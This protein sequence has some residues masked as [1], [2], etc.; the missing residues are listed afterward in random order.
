MQVMAQA[1]RPWVHV[2]VGIPG[3]DAD[4]HSGMPSV[5]SFVFGVHVVLRS[6]ERGRGRFNAES[7]GHERTVHQDSDERRSARVHG[8]SRE[9]RANSPRC[10]SARPHDDSALEGGNQIPTH[11]EQIRQGVAHLRTR[12]QA[13][14]LSRTPRRSVRSPHGRPGLV[15]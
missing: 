4:D 15:L 8:L 11:G 3:G 6:A 13:Q 5:V 7:G 2:W 1:M 12:G 10:D 14:K 9:T